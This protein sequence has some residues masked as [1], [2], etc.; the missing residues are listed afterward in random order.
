MS[1]ETNAEGLLET[2]QA[3]TD[4]LTEEFESKDIFL[5]GDSVLILS[6]NRAV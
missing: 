4:A 6:R 3:G 5:F 1:D 2:T